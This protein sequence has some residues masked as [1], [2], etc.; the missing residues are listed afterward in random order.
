MREGRV[1]PPLRVLC[2]VLWAAAAASGCALLSAPLKQRVEIT[3]S[4]PGATVTVTPGGEKIVTPGSLRLRRS[5]RYYLEARL[6]GHHEELAPVG[7]YR[8]PFE[9]ALFLPYSLDRRVSIGLDPVR[10][11]GGVARP[12]LPPLPGPGVALEIDFPPKGAALGGSGGMAFVSGRA[13]A[14]TAAELRRFD[15]ILA[16][17][18]SGSTGVASGFDVDGDGE[19]GT[20]GFAR[21]LV[22]LF[23]A[24]WVGASSDWGD[25][26]LQAE[27]HVAQK[28]L[29]RLDPRSTRVGLVTFAG[30]RDVQT[31][32]AWTLVPLTR[33]HERVRE[34]LQSLLDKGPEGRTNLLS[35]VQLATSE[36]VGTASSQSSYRAETAARVILMS[37][38]EPTLPYGDGQSLNQSVAVQAA[39]RAAQLGVR[40]DTIAVSVQGR[41]ADQALRAVAERAGGELRRLELEGP[42]TDLG[43]GAGLTEVEALRITNQTT[44]QVATYR[45]LGADGTFGALV[46]MVPGSN[47]IE[48]YAQG[49]QGLESTTSYTFQYDPSVAPRP[50]TPAA[51][52]IRGALLERRLQDLRGHPAGPR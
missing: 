14:F 38:G 2:Q 7:A 26:V 24:R 45:E 19:V 30:D 11:K 42:M 4:P 6:E 37:D 5:G 31:P 51:R 36:L 50:L 10:P 29:E 46:P 47:Q 1:L 20:T 12:V 33:D 39:A 9:L 13:V 44:D 41:Y 48:V 16:I 22:S 27:I 18:V 32:D 34:G 8:P 43:S 21:Q 40:I 15:V 49:A 35:A 25:S 23:T 28:I 52:R 17:D 3:S